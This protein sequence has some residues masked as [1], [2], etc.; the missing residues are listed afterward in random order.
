MPWRA[1]A[2]DDWPPYWLKVQLQGYNSKWKTFC[3]NWTRWGGGGHRPAE[4]EERQRESTEFSV[5][6]DQL[7]NMAEGLPSTLTDYDLAEDMAVRIA[8]L[9]QGVRQ[10][11]EAT[12]DQGGLQT[13]EAKEGARTALKA[14]A[15]ARGRALDGNRDWLTN[16]WLLTVASLLEEGDALAYELQ[17]VPAEV[18]CSDVL[19]MHEGANERHLE[20][21]AS[22]ERTGGAAPFPGRQRRQPSQAAGSSDTGMGAEPGGDHVVR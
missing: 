2:S 21:Q 14:M 10:L 5:L 8:M 7:R 3:Y 4:G 13:I 22:A 9:N 16:N 12:R 18:H 6:M 19:V 15:S 20:S 1:A 11:E 17:H